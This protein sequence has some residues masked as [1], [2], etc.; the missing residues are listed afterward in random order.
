[1]DSRGQIMK[2]DSGTEIKLQSIFP[3]VAE[4]WRRVADDMDE[5]HNVQLRITEGYR[6]FEVQQSYYAKGREQTRDG[7]WV[8]TE[9]KKV[10][11][12]AKPGQS[13]HQY[14]LAMDVC[15]LGPNPFPKE[16]AF[17]VKYGDLLKKYGLQWGGDWTG[18]SVDQPHCED[19][20][21]FTLKELEALYSKNDNIQDVWEACATRMVPDGENK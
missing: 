4:R 6:S 7:I 10:I 17:W 16:R 11:T 2:L 8:V 9:L 21:G 12:H 1:M 13:L 19:K 18:A 3:D 14:G 15:A 20:Y 5:L